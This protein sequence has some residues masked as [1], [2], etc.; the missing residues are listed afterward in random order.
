MCI[1]VWLFK[2][3]EFLRQ[4]VL[5]VSQKGKRPTR[6]VPMRTPIN[7]A[8]NFNRVHWVRRRYS[9]LAPNEPFVLPSWEINSTF[10][11]LF[12]ALCMCLCYGKNGFSLKMY[13][14]RCVV[15]Y[16]YEAWRWCRVQ[17]QVE[18]ILKLSD[19]VLL[20]FWSW[21]KESFAHCWPI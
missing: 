9:L 20:L 18:G 3:L 5:T 13:G 6:P 16:V 11:S 1:F 10:T 12:V 19:K 2:Y 8:S 21:K 14:S 7:L 4:P 15:M 17:A